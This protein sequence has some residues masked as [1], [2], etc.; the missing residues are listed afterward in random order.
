[1]AAVEVEQIAEVPPGML[2]L[3]IP[4]NSY[5]VYTHRGH[6]ARIGDTVK[7]VW[8]E[9]LPASRYQHVPA[10]DFEFYDARFDPETGKGEVD[11]YVPIVDPG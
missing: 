5:A 2:A 3:C 11:I 4:A 10:P 1:V 6:I 8:G 7:S 9:W